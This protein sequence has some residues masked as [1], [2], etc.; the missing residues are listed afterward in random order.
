MEK[1]LGKAWPERYALPTMSDS[2]VKP[3][4]GPHTDLVKTEGVRIS[5]CTC[6]T[7]HV[8]LVRNGTTVQIAPEYFAE[9][10]QAMSLA[11]TVMAGAQAPTP[12]LQPTTPTG[13]FITLP[14]FGGKKPSN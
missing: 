2:E 7:I 10:A 1:A 3:T 13:G 14:V 12:A 8:N 11:K 9:I 6:G 5:R 4:C